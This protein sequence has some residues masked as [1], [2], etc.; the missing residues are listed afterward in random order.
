MATAI[1]FLRSDIKSL[2]PTPLSLSEGMP[3]VN[4]NA[5][6]PGLYMRLHDQSLMKIGPTSIGEN[7]PNYAATGYAS[8]CVGEQWLDTSISDDKPR[9][10]L[11]AWDGINWVEVDGGIQDH[12]LKQDKNTIYAGPTLGTPSLPTF[13]AMVYDDI[14][15]DVPVDKLADSAPGKLIVG[16][17]AGWSSEFLDMGDDSITQTVGENLVRLEVTAGNIAGTGP[18]GTIKSGDGHIQLNYD[19]IYTADSRLKFVRDGA[20]LLHSYSSTE[21]GNNTTTHTHTFMGAMSI[22]GDVDITNTYDLTVGGDLVVGHNATIGSDPVELLRVYNKSE[23][24]SDVVVKDFNNFF[25]EHDAQIDGNT[26]IGT[27]EANTLVVNAESTFLADVLIGRGC[28]SDSLTVD[29]VTLIKCD[30]TIE[31]ELNTSGGDV[32]FPW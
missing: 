13:R 6:D 26:I 31:G 3:M 11:K 10:V 18:D 27:A 24:Y 8:L 7:P 4:F 1:Q 2:R 15:D 25:A 20:G 21:F 16:G 9:A 29:A 22:S 23:F 14:P 12:E 17:T 30:L 5:A 32:T 19:G 28:L